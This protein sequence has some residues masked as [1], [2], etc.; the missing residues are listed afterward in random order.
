MSG[1]NNQWIRKINL[2]L[3]GLTSTQGLDLSDFRIKFNIQNADFETPNTASI[4]V[5]NLAESLVQA[6]T[7]PASGE[8][9][10]VRVSAGYVNGNYGTIFEG[11]VKQFHIGKENN[12]DT[13]L[14]I[15][16]SDG[17][18]FYNQSVLNTTLSKGSTPQSL[19]KVISDSNNIPF[20]VSGL[21]NGAITNP[22][23]R[24]QTLV[25]MTRAFLRNTANTLKATWSV[26]NGVVTV[27]SNDGYKPSGEAVEINVATGL[28]GT[29]EQTDQGIQLT[30]LLNSKLQIGDLL[31][32]NS[33]EILQ[34]IQ[35]QS[36]P[37][38]T[39]YNS[40][41]NVQFYVPLAG[42]D[43]LYRAYV[44]EHEGDTRG[45]AWY[46]HIV[47]LAMNPDTKTVAVKTVPSNVVSPL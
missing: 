47:C 35:G 33:T 18:V 46:S 37:T 19:F 43:N 15:L 44:V 27:L 3:Y 29:P 21:A 7:N 20:D 16:A 41:S 40:I 26:Q 12:K 9:S 39:A 34:T 22:S 10:Q 2:I 24:G 30:C 13:Y 17:D 36:N 4:R 31:K 42:S 5:Y 25:G 14:D 1:N 32:L 23:I 8:F 11:T 38:A 6:V 45:H 28:I